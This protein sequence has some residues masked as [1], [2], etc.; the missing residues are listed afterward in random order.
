MSHFKIVVEVPKGKLEQFMK[1]AM[2]PWSMEIQGY[3]EDQA[4]EVT[5]GASKPRKKKRSRRGKPD[6]KLT[7]TGKR[8]QIPGG[9]IEKGL[10]L[11]E[12][13]EGDMGIGTVS[14]AAFMKHLNVKRVPDGMLNRLVAEGYVDYL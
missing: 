10:D 12:K 9:K 2:G 6:I 7:M 1:I 3:V 4:A 8:P 14:A 11:F 5:N 13:L